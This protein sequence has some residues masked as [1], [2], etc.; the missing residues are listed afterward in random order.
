MCILDFC[1]F[2]HYSEI[3]NLRRS[4]ITFHD[5]FRKVFIEKYKTDVY[6]EGNWI[7]IIKSI[8]NLCPVKIIQNYFNFAL[9]NDKSG[10]YIF[11]A[12]T[13]TKTM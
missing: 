9:I 4:G 5:T 10:E 3:S 2:M 12:I 1:G 8:G 6:R 7:Y 11:R 13:K